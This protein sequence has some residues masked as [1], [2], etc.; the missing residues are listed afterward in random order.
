MGQ[1]A[2]ED[3]VAIANLTSTLTGIGKADASRGR[4]SQRLAD[5]MLA[6][7]DRDR[8]PSPSVVVGFADELTAALYGKALSV[9]SVA[10]LQQSILE[11][12]RGSSA[13]FA[14]AASLR[15]ILSQA[16]VDAAESTTH[17]QTFHGDRRGNQR[18]GRR[19]SQQKQIVL[20]RCLLCS[21]LFA[22]ALRGQTAA[23]D[24][25]AIAN[26][27]STLVGIEVLKR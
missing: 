18:A 5:D 21:L 9:R 2:G 10:V 17:H 27:T 26:L 11:V 24:K 14:P 23:D 12:L 22:A 4:L 8:E 13:T 3:K 20:M 6:L 16:G 15:Q 19:P 1:T 7:A 25:V